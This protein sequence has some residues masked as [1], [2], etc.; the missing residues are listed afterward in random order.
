MVFE[1]ILLV[2]AP[3]V[4]VVAIYLI[5]KIYNRNINKRLNDIDSDIR[6]IQ[7][8]IETDI[9]AGVYNKN[10]YD[11]DMGRVINYYYRRNVGKKNV[12][13]ISKVAGVVVKTVGLMLKTMMIC[14]G[15]ID[16]IEGVLNGLIIEVENGFS[17]DGIKPILE[18]LNLFKLEIIDIVLDVYN[19]KEIRVV[20]A[21]QDII[22]HIFSWKIIINYKSIGGSCCRGEVVYDW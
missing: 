9:D 7:H 4:S 5:I 17:F 16:N 13:V 21:T 2:L 18:C 6:H 22:K 12:D 19:K 3:V 10:T 8:E 14:D 11:I 1:V 20:K 15:R